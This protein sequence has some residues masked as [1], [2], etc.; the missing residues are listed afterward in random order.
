MNTCNNCGSQLVLYRMKSM[1]SPELGDDG[2]VAAL[3]WN[4]D[5]LSTFEETC[6]REW[7][8]TN[9]I[10]G[11]AAGTAALANTRRYHGLLFA[12]LRPPVERVALVMK[13]E[14][15]ASYGGKLVPLA[16]NEFADG[17]IAPQG[18][19]HLESFRL[20]GLT[21]VWQWLIDDVRLEQRL[22]MRYGENTTY[23]EFRRFGGNQPLHLSIAP[24]CTS[25]D[26][27]AQSRGERAFGIE[28]VADGVR[29]HAP[30]GAPSYDIIGV[31]AEVVI[32]PQWF[33]Q[34][35]HRHE[36]ARGLDDL[37]DLFHPASFAFKL[38]A[39]SVVSVILTAEPHP[40]LATY[41][42]KTAEEIRQKSL[43]A[44]WKIGWPTRLSAD[45]T[46]LVDRLVL[47][48]D[49]FLVQRH[50]PSG[51]PLGM[52]VI[53]GYPW[54]TDWGRDTLI[55]LPGLTVATGRAPIAASV[56]R[57]F[58]HYVSEGLIPNRF[59]D[60]GDS[61]EYN[62]AD[63]GLWFFVAVHEYLRAINDADFLS[64]I[65]PI[66]R[67][68][69]ERHCS[70]TRFGIRMDA[71]DCLLHSGE[72]GVQVT[73]MDAKVGEW[74]VTPRIGKAVEINALWFNAV[75]I[76]R[77]LA[78]D[79]GIAHDQAEYATLAGRIHASFNRSFW[80][81]DGGYLY[82][83]IDGPEGEADPAGRRRDSSLRPNQ[84]FSLSLP[85]TL[86]TGPRAR[87]LLSVCHARLWTP[88]GLR[89]LAAGDSRYAGHYGG[90]AERR[91]GAYHQGTVWTWL[92]GPFVIAH[93]RVYGDRAAA[94]DLLRGIPAHLR[95]AC[96]GQISEIMDGDAPFRPAGCFAQAWSVAEIL[97]ALRELR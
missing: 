44:Q 88:V 15:T 95:E 9:G 27:H 28:P 58:A 64:E 91:D 26:Y 48:A 47:A 73:W 51:G 68:M 96:I 24:L 8:V 83:V 77:D 65:Y 52:S 40:P 18:F 39:G 89:S 10:G 69:L 42:A 70:G 66:L 2:F 14:V 45:E 32:Q 85:Y 31:G 25:R 49:Q 41:Q 33:W 43:R 21:P 7:L 87:Q 19:C 81:D 54:F 3:E 53:A 38:D 34:F 86:I 74:V 16:T 57:T 90:N 12:A 97:R 29:I 63:A 82:D 78:A 80:F 36:S 5:V 23:V 37:E 61:V 84:I 6:R 92:L 22:W 4:R 79:L 13:L 93:Y 75:S 50:D 30:D 56:L 46:E 72:S 11:F 67:D 60:R 59:P 94:A 62:T 20:E 71:D 55:A 1:N 17:T 76:L 35:K